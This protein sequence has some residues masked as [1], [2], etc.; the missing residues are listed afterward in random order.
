[1]Q[2]RV[3]RVGGAHVAPALAIAMLVGCAAQDPDATPGEADRLAQTAAEGAPAGASPA[4]CKT[5]DSSFAAIQE[6]IFERKGC[7]ANACHGGAKV[8]GLDL[9]KD[10]AWESLVDAASANSANARIQP[11]SSLESYLYQKL[12]AATHPGSVQVSGAPMPIGTPPLSEKELEAVQLWIQKGAPKTGVVA[13]LNKDLDVGKLLD[14]CLPPSQPVKIKPLEP[15]TAAEGVQM[16]MPRYTLK[17]DSEVEQCTPFVYDFTDRVPAQYRDDARNVMYVKSLRVRQDPQSHHLVVWNPKRDLATVGADGASWTCRGG[18]RESAS[19]DPL[20]GSKDCGAGGV[21]AGK[22]VK[23]TFCGANGSE[24]GAGGTIAGINIA[25]L[26]DPT[27]RA[28]LLKDPAVAEA[29][30]KAAASGALGGGAV[31]ESIANTQA[32]QEYIAPTDGVYWEVPLRGVMWFN[33]HAFNLE[34]ADTV[35]ESRVNYYFAEKRERLMR[36][37]TTTQNIYVAAGQAPFT[38]KSYCAKSVVPQ[39]YSLAIMSSHTHRRGE[40]FW[41]NDAS[42]KQ[43]YENFI[44]NDPLNKRFTPWI[45]FDSPDPAA[46]TLEYCATFNNGL[47]K[48]DRPDLNLVT[49]ASRMP[50]GKTCKAVACVAGKVTAACNQNSDCDSNPGRGDGQCD[51][52]AIQ[53][54]QTTEDEMFVLSP[55]YVLPPKQ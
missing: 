55:W 43:I 27:K 26:M 54:G 2:V 21:C 28:E 32:P 49:R 33:S 25:D 50:E 17:A 15:P 46:R 4:D 39:G 19:C 44:Y 10:A 14:A 29:L 23:G 40:R 47:T 36:Q 16:H 53:A 13:D 3:H 12:A 24:L 7:T 1:M 5:F 48:D 6:L 35:L 45:V 20:K 37:G 18:D 8:G 38:R 34:T 9:R 30:R 52:C 41:V 31:S 11:G 42:G 22:T 51:A